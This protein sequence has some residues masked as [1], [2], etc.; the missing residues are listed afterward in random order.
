M[1]PDLDWLLTLAGCGDP[2]V[3]M[4]RGKLCSSITSGVLEREEDNA[5]IHIHTHTY[6]THSTDGVHYRDKVAGN[7][8]NFLL[9]GCLLAKSVCVCV[10]VS[11]SL[12]VCVCL[13]VCVRIPGGSLF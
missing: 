10:C 12:S 4:R 13:C 1:L 9:V 7:R 2:T 6:S 3:R 8:N 5:Q 11:L